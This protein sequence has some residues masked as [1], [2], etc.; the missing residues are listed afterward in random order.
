MSPRR[1]RFRAMAVSRPA[2]LVLAGTLAALAVPSTASAAAVVAGQKCARSGTPTFNMITSGWAPGASLTIHLGSF[3][4]TVTADGSGV[5]STAGSPLTTP[6]LGRPGV[7]TLSLTVTDG[8]TTAGP[9]RTK[10]VRRGVRVPARAKP[11]QTVRY[12]GYGFPLHKRLYLHVRR[13]GKTKGTFRIGRPGG[14]CGLVTRKL[15]YMPLRRWS[16]GTYDYWFSNTRKFRKSRTLYG[17]RISIYRKF[18]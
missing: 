13:G 18:G 6:V 2:L 12:R 11:A 7:K 14:A 15:R 1:V 9:A 3:G 10:V 5:F 8:V 17:Y 4:R 16:T